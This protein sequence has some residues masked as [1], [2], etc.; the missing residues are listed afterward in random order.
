MSLVWAGRLLASPLP[1]R[2]G[3]DLFETLLVEAD[4]RALSVYFSERPKPY[5]EG[6]SGLQ[7]VS[8]PDCGCAERLPS[9]AEP[10]IAADIRRSSADLL[11]IAMTSPRKESYRTWARPLPQ[12]APRGG[13]P[14]DVFAGHVARALTVATARPEWLYRVLQSRAAC[15]GDTPDEHDLR[16]SARKDSSRRLTLRDDR[17]CHGRTR[18]EESEF[19][20]SSASAGSTGGITI[21][22]TRPADDESAAAMF[23]SSTN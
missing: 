15:G 9:S 6:S 10:G 3:I 22:A 11:F 2:A 8:R 7:R 16:G 5:S 18:F 12:G 1:E 23:P 21:A 13:R 19:D 20:G 14:F 4:C 17:R